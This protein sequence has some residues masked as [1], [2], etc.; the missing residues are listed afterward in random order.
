MGIFKKCWD[1]K[2]F[3][4]SFFMRVYIE[5]YNT[6]KSNMRGTKTSADNLLNS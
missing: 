4:Y 1:S 6:S 3:E 5:K 2:F